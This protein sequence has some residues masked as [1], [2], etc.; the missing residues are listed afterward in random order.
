MAFDSL[1]FVA[2]HGI[3]LQSPRHPAVPT[4]TEAIVGGR[5]RGSWWGHPR[6]HEIYRSLQAVYASP[7]VVATRLVDGKVTLV[8]RRVWPALA[9]LER[10]GRVDRRGLVRVTEEHTASG[11]HRRLEEPFPEW[12]PPGLALPGEEEAVRQLGSALAAVVAAAK[13]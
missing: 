1:G 11:R 6:A 7:D 3:V 5:I 12:L 8:H 2:V 13:G 10:A 9:A 4:L